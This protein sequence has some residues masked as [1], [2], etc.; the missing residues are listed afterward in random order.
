MTEEHHE[1]NID[2]SIMNAEEE[3]SNAI[4]VFHVAL[5]DPMIRPGT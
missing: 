3:L 1:A 2:T 4:S 5:A